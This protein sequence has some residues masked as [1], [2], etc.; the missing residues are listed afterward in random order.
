MSN[1]K[2]VNPFSIAFLD[3]MSS[4]LAAVIILFVIVPKSDI[5]ID[6]AETS[7]DEM[8]TG[9]QEVDSIIKSWSLYMS[10]SEIAFLLSKTD[11]LKQSME[12]TQEAFRMTQLRLDETKRQNDQLNGRLTIAEKRIAQL[13]A[14]LKQSKPK[15]ETPKSEKAANAQTPIASAKSTPESTPTTPQ[16]TQSKDKNQF[17]TDGKGDFFF[18]LDA[19]LVT[20]ISWEDDK[21]DI[22]LH[23]KD[24]R[25]VLLDYY[26]RKTS[27]GQWV[28]VPRKFQNTPNQ[29]IIQNEL[30]PGKYEVHAHMRKP[31]KGENA[32]ISG[33]A[34]ISPKGGK[35]KKIDF[36]KITVSPGPPPHKSGASTLIGTLVITENDIQW[37]RS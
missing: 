22:T 14:E 24:E 1:R 19:P 8:K 9:F 3:L 29:A 28:K 30:V 35:S 20:M 5:Q 11:Q 17:E 27:F 33:F 32:T 21:Y 12:E 18:G 25:G 23:L 15:T 4:A 6:I 10:E 13:E 36:G 37:S 2:E 16:P 34:A 31:R 26:S 7:F